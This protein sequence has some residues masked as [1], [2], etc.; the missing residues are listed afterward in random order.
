LKNNDYSGAQATFHL[1]SLRSYTNTLYNYTTPKGSSSYRSHICLPDVFQSALDS[2]SKN[3]MFVKQRSIAASIIYYSNAVFIRYKQDFIE[4]DSM[5]IFRL[6][7]E[8]KTR[9]NQSVRSLFVKYYKIY[10][11]KDLNKTKDEESYDQ[12]HESKLKE[13][14]SQIS[15]DICIYRKKN[16]AAIITASQLTK[17][18]KKLSIRYSEAIAQPKLSDNVRLALYLL[19]KDQKSLDIIKSNQLLELVRSLMAI[20]STKQH[21]YFK[22]VINDIQNE[23]VKDLNIEAWYGGLSVQSIATSKNFI[24]YYLAIFLRSYI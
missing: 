5:R 16:N 8:I 20:K 2:L 7:Y 17:F 19:L 21:I 1:F 6:I 24:A 23:I 9:I 3:H 14:V 12:S 13:F 18:N 22:K 11:D 4:D 10:K 15:N